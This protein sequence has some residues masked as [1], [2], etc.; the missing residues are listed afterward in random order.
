MYIPEWTTDCN[1]GVWIKGDRDFGSTYGC[2]NWYG[3]G[4]YRQTSV[5]FDGSISTTFSG[6]GRAELDFGNCF[7]KG[8]LDTLGEG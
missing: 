6:D 7:I 1:R 5:Q 4:A 2:I 3:W 8:G